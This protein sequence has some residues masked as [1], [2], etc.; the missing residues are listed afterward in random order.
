MKQHAQLCGLIIAPH[1]EGQFTSQVASFVNSDLT[2][3][4]CSLL[5]QAKDKL[6][7]IFLHL[8]SCT[9]FFGGG[10]GVTDRTPPVLKL[11]VVLV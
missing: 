5:K 11:L 1:G 2:L 10:E 3:I 4:F 7:Q 6:V 8:T 9:D